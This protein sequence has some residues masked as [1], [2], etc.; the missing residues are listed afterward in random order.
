MPEPARADAALK[1]STRNKRAILL[2]FLSVRG[3]AERVTDL[4][5]RPFPLLAD[6]QKSCAIRRVYFVSSPKPHGMSVQS[7]LRSETAKQSGLAGGGR[8]FGAVVAAPAVFARIVLDVLATGTDRLRG[9]ILTVTLRVPLLDR[10]FRSRTKRLSVI[11][12]ASLLVALG[13]ALTAPLWM[14]LIVPLILGVPHLVASLNF[15]LRLTA[16]RME[17]RG[18]A[19][20]AKVGACFVAVA[21]VRL[22]APSQGILENV[23][24]GVEIVAALAGGVWL[25][26]ASRAAA[27]RAVASAA[28][29]VA[30]AAGSL[31]A[32]AETLGVLVLAHNFVGFAYWIARAPTAQDRQ[33]ALAALA[34]FTAATAA[35]LA[36]AFDQVLAQRTADILGGGMSDFDTG[37]TI[38]PGTEREILLRRAVSAFALGQSL[39]YFVWLRAIPEQELPH[40]HPIGFS[41]S[42]RFIELNPGRLVLYSAAYGVAAL[43]AYAFI[44]GWVEARLLY[45]SAAAFHG[46]FEIAGLALVRSA[47][48]TVPR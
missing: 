1:G 23:P 16:G 9:R 22:W 36:G 13:L 4:G 17:E 44:Y 7:A 38:L 6:K 28:I 24:N 5:M 25:A 47:S 15:V 26:W 45:L 43:F 46:Y 18:G 35:I 14:L 21:A 37:Q 11:F 29:L 30:L 40:Q 39:H 19:L 41:K 20:P 12:A 33:V 8:I 2:V 31:A 10:I 32:P 42:L 34:L 27:V 48:L 3:V